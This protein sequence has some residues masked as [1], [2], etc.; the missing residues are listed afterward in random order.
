MSEKEKQIVEKSNNLIEA[1]YKLSLAEQRLIIMA[2]M[3]LKENKTENENK[4][5]VSFF[6]N[7]MDE[8]FDSQI[9]YDYY[10]DLCRG[11]MKKQIKMIKN[12]DPKKKNNVEINWISSI[13]YNSGWIEIEFSEKLIPY[14]IELSDSYTRYEIQ[15]ISRMKSVYSIRIYEMLKQ[16]QDTGFKIIKIEDL[17]EILQ[18]GDSFKEYKYLKRNLIDVS[19]KEINDNTDLYVIYKPI[20][21]G[22]S[23]ESAQFI[24]KKKGQNL[25]ENT[26]KTTDL[27]YISKYIINIDDYYISDMNILSILNQGYT[28]E[29]IVE[30]YYLL[31][32]Q[33]NVLNKVGWILTALKEDYEV[34]ESLDEIINNLIAYKNYIENSKIQK[35][36]D[37]TD[38]KG[39]K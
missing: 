5:T 10:I 37:L 11:L 9:N 31:T 23:Y 18:T 25:V 26:D 8:I 33:R 21:K 3:K 2:C 34:N 1:Q 39:G 15:N 28:K 7:E 12:L 6:M 16:Y 22:R 36:R 35:L 24:I 27:E 19:L 32:M 20:R 4:N 38:T 13:E 14:L 29:K 17:R 30:K